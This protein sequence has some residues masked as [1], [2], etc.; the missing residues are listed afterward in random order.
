MN[1]KDECKDWAE[2][3][4]CLKNPRYMY[5][6]C[7]KS[8]GVCDDETNT[9]AAAPN[10]MRNLNILNSEESE[11]VTC[12]EGVCTI[13]LDVDVDDPCR[14]TT[15]EN[16]MFWANMGECKTNPFF[17]LSNCAKSCGKCTRLVERGNDAN[18]EEICLDDDPK[19]ECED[20]VSKGDCYF[21]LSSMKIKCAASCVMCANRN[22]LKSS[23]VSDE[24]M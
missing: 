2:L 10:I 15:P 9:T 4:E 5:K 12:E 21:D 22:A 16:C 13:M 6:H 7:M 3:G 8:C 18:A 24:E 17:M 20:H 1:Q 19:G 14:D 23:G 11:S